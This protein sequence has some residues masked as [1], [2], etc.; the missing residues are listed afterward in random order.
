[1]PDSLFL[2][3]RRRLILEQLHLHGRVSV[4]ALSD[5]LDVSAVTIRQ[6]LQAL[7]NEKLLKRTHGGAM[8]LNRDPASEQSELSFDLRRQKNTAEKD[9]IGKAAAAFV[10]NGFGIAFDAS[11]TVCSVIPHLRHLNALTIVTNNLLIT[12]QVLDLPQ[13]EVLL[14][15]GQ[16]RRSANSITGGSDSLPDINLAVGFFSAWGVTYE[17]G[18]TEV[19]R[20][21]ME[22]KKALL[23]R[24]ALSIV[25][26]DSTKWGK[27]A[28]YTYATSAG[29]SRII[30]TEL[31]PP[32]LVQPFR[33]AG[34]TL[35]IV[36]QP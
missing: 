6:D 21:E 34:V 20:E 10:E 18:F 11:T 22:M 13:F 15:S 23:A 1:M 5:A 19:D 4:K 29:I 31:A 8:L 36:A 25:L 30:T 14:P 32:S 33:D 24:C 26:V 12:G 7:E 9:A 35:E 17:S 2:E 3:E 27:V 28:P 16:L